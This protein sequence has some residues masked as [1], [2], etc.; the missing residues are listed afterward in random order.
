MREIAEAFARRML[1]EG[2]YENDEVIVEAFVSHCVQLDDS[3]G[4]AFNGAAEYA[5]HL[6]VSIEELVDA[7]LMANWGFFLAGMG[8]AVKTLQGPEH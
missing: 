4:G 5:E 1:T 6:G 2:E 8:A 7:S 3:P